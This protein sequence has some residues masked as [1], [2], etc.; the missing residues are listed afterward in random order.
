VLKAME[1]LGIILLGEGRYADAEK[2]LRETLGFD[3]RVFGEDNRA[4]AEVAY[5]LACS[6]ARQN[7]RDEA[8]SVLQDAVKHKLASDII[9]DM[10]KDPDL[11]SLHGDPRFE[12]LVAKAPQAVASTK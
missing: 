11:K 12:A 8:I 1:H 5:N 3:R 10:N 2:L 6:I 7:R 4:T 9:A